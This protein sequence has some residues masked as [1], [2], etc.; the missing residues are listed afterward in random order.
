MTP[1]AA[2]ILSAD[3]LEVRRR[4]RREGRRYRMVASTIRLCDGDRYALAAPNGA[5]KSTLLALLSLVLAPDSA[6]HFAM[7][8]DDDTEVD[9][10]ARAGRAGGRLLQAL[11]AREIGA[12]RHAGV[13]APF[14]SVHDHVA[15]RLRLAGNDDR[16]A[17]ATTLDTLDLSP[18]QHAKPSALSQGQ[19]QRMV[20]AAALAPRPRLVFADEPTAA[21]D[22][23]WG[24][25]VMALLA[26]YRPA[27]GRGAVLV[28]THD[29]ALAAAAGFTVLR[30]HGHAME[31]DGE[32]RWTFAIGHGEP[33]RA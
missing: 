12:I 21:L 32:V 18:L 22:A 7:R 3:Q 9:L 6:A 16:S 11:R 23:E 17:A 27:H 8:L 31:A 14:L 19:R 5:G 30:P 20:V 24:P 28:A 15:L 29:P 2:P 26:Q 10:V 4:D 13:E 1:A 25:R 33:A